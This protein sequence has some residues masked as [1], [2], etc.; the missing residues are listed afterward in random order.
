M[1]TYC[2]N[3]TTITHEVSPRI[4]TC[5]PKNLSLAARLEFSKFQNCNSYMKTARSCCCPLMERPVPGGPGFTNVGYTANWIHGQVAS[6]L[7]PKT[8]RSRATDPG[9]FYGCFFKP[10]PPISWEGKIVKR[11]AHLAP[12]LRPP[13][14]RFWGHFTKVC[15]VAK[16]P[17]RKKFG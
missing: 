8:N 16:G 10:P 7:L 15:M 17:G 3:I 9:C 2:T 4:R 14:G 6:V 13:W 11:P 5:L 1:S 12:I